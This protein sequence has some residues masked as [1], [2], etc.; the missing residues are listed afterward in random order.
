MMCFLNSFYAFVA[1]ACAAASP[2]CTEF[3]R[4]KS[5]PG[6]PSPVRTSE[7]PHGVPQLSA[8]E[9]ARWQSSQTLLERCVQ[10]LKTTCASG[11]HGHFEHP[12]NSLA[13]QDPSL[14][15]WMQ[16][17]AFY[18]FAVAACMHNM[19]IE[20][21]WMFACTLESLEP[22]AC[23]CSHQER[24]S[25]FVGVQDNSGRWLSRTT[26][27]YP[28]SLAQQF[29][30][31]TQH[32][33]SVGPEL[34]PQQA[35]STVPMKDLY[36]P[37]HSQVDGGGI[38]SRADW[39]EPF[40]HPNRF[41]PLRDAWIPL[42]LR[43]GLRHQLIQKCN[44]HSPNPPFAQDTVHM[45][46][47]ALEEALRPH[48]P[49]WDWSIPPEQ[50]F[51]L[52]A[53]HSLCAFIGDPDTA[54]F[55]A[56]LQG[57]PTGFQHNIPAS[58]VFSPKPET[59]DHPASPLSHHF[60]NWKSAEDHTDITN[61]LLQEEIRQGWVF[62]FEGSLQQAQQ[63]W[64]QGVALGKLSI[65]FSATRS[66]RLVLDNTVSGTNN[67]CVVPEKQS[68]PSAWD[69]M[70]SFPLRNTQSP[71]SAFSLDVKAAHKHIR[72]H[73]SE[74]GLLGFTF[75]NRL[76]FYRTCPFGAI[77]SQHW[78]GRLGSFLLR[79]W[80]EVLFMSHALF[81]FV[82]DFLLTQDFQVLPVSAVILVMLC[83]ILSRRSARWALR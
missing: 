12:L 72:V 4:L 44:D 43:L 74:Q 30:S 63:E 16:F 67:A 23:S 3:S 39:S 57:V 54:L 77:F 41:K 15:H 73:P 71:Q 80:R 22:M 45:F 50:P 49:A 9:N 48:I 65:A 58:H 17:Y 6:G 35:L 21:T 7:H 70:R 81:L 28:V 82:D 29:A 20:K 10:C 69:V 5:L 59:S 64:P 66:P 78:W 11:G 34:Q 46:R 36:Q 62:E 18:C 60:L 47:E 61:S 83:Q 26:A 24:H 38:P 19:M 51:C 37:P 42:I 2:P 32:L 75:Q 76:F 33:F 55:P 8:S 53:L 52:R 40:A 31:L 27:I 14:I 56:L 25:S 68:M 1:R 79:L 13:W